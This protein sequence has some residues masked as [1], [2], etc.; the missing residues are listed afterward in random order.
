MKSYS[1]ELEKNTSTEIETRIAKVMLIIK[2]R[3]VAL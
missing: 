2:N 3:L 1:T